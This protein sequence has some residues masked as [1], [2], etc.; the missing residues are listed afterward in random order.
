[1]KLILSRKGF[2][3]SAGGCPSPVFPDGSF[4]S[5][6]IPDK[7]SSVRYSDLQYEGIN[8]G[9]LVADL[10]G[11]PKRRDHRAHL[12]PDLAPELTSRKP[13]WRPT[14][15]QIDQA[16]GHLRNQGV[17][18]GDLFL[19]FGLFRRVERVD[20]RWRFDRQSA[21][22]HA[23]W[24]WLQVEEVSPV[25]GALG[26]RL[27]WVQDHPHF[28]REAKPSNTLYIARESL[29]LGRG[30]MRIQG[31]GVF[32]SMNDELRLTVPG[33]KKVSVWQLPGF[34]Y[35]S[36][37]KRPLSQ[38]DDLSRWQL[39][40]EQCRLQCVPRGQEFVLDTSDYPEA[41]S[42]IESLVK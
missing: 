7:Q 35:P 11:N 28:H 5:L 15:G 32:Q 22:F 30:P 29:D 17:S 37:G 27:P 26:E 40:G 8:V 3:S 23:L 6:P 24:G 34:F 9:E 33:S 19:F 2:D 25:D 12:D 21:P 31:A 13:G 18:E 42:W 10:T 41:F 36:E 39:D 38:H 20:G 16:Q 14:L 1:M 4:L